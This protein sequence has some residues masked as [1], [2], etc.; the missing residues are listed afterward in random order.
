[1]PEESNTNNTNLKFIIVLVIFILSGYQIYSGVALKKMGIPGFFEVYFSAVKCEFE[2]VSPN[3]NAEVSSSFTVYGTAQN[4][5]STGVNYTLAI[6]D[7]WQSYY[8]QNKDIAVSNSGTWTDDIKSPGQWVGKTLTIR[9][10][11]Y[12][13][14]VTLEDDNQNLPN[15]SKV[16]STIKVR[17]Q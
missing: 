10:I 5:V 6:L 1:M 7:P 16:L 14:S 8:Y 2:I 12:P 15:G 3:D 13:A 11:T 17:V 9:A 4:C